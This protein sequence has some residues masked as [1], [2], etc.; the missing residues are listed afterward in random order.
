MEAP[1]DA[2][3]QKADCSH[4][5]T[6]RNCPISNTPCLGECIF[7]TIL[8]NINLGI[9]GFDVR[10]R[11]VFFQNRQAIELFR[12]TIRPKDFDALAPLLLP[13]FEPCES[14]NLNEPATLRYGN[15]F[16]GYTVYCISEIYYWIY[17]SDITERMR[18]NSIAEAVNTMNNLGYI[19]SG[20]RHELGN[21]IN[22]IKTT[23][24]VC[25]K[26]LETYSKDTI[27]QVMDR[28]L[29]DIGRVE[30]L[31]KDLKNFSMFEN[32]E[33]KNVHMT[34]FMNNLLSIV[35]RD[36]SNNDIRISTLFRP[37]VEYGYFDARALHQVMLNILTNASDALRG[38]PSQEIIIGIQKAGD[39]IVIRVKDNGCGI[40]NEQKKHLF[41]PFSTTKDH[42][43]GLGL[44]I[45]KKMMLKMDGTVEIES[46]E[47]IGSTV[48]LTLP[49]G[50]EGLA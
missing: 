19:F 8:D 23:L 22:S 39:R 15:R 46:Q 36:F 27:G 44:V 25:K 48:T 10:K 18:L 3:L 32:P 47:N 5:E 40:P 35:R 2:N 45:V 4:K 34:S 42:G 13:S 26:N 29:S 33:L 17:I 38:R 50:R 24:T 6:G 1:Q 30:G 16:I 37:D 9:I 12:G 41:Q 7:A 11:E 21:P 43:T 20:I 14:A 28:I 49:E 31:L